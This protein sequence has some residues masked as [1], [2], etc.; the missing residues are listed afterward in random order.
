METIV[1]YLYVAAAVLFVLSL[2]WMSE[3]KTSRMGNWA[4]SA[5]MLIAVAATM[6]AFKTEHYNLVIIA[7]AA[8]TIIGVPIALKLP[9][10]AVPQRTAVS[11]AFGSLAVAL[12]GTAEYYQ[13]VP[14]ID[15]FTMTVLAFEMILGYLTFTGS[16]IAFLKL[17]ETISG[18][19]LIYRGRN[20]VS[21]VIVAVAVAMA[22]GLVV[23]PA[24]TV[25]LP[26]LVISALVFG[27]LLVMS[28]GGADMPTVIAILNSYAGLSAAA[29]GFVLNNQ[30]LIVAGTLDGAS[31]FILAV[32]MCK[33]MNRSFIN[34]LFGGFGATTTGG[35]NVSGSI[36]PVSA[37]EAYFILE[38]ARSVVFVPGYG[39]A[40]A[41]AQH[42]LQELGELLE[43]NGAEVSYGIHPVAG[44]MP[45]H[46]NVLL[47]EADVSYD[48]LIEAELINP[49]MPITDVCMVIGANDV[50]NP[51][52]KE[53]KTSPLWGM[54]IIE[55]DKCRTVI[56]L[57]RS[58]RP[59]F[60]GVENPL[61]FK[62]NTRMLFGDAKASIQSLISEFK[63]A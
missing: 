50:V 25:F 52:A 21:G 39:L 63:S 58:M 15:K 13:H 4:G 19:P 11:H 41:Q 48:Q 54:P 59:G 12:V 43:K 2:K 32:I 18:K 44:R 10:A 3:V 42:V 38:G 53:D 33:A 30:L 31:G 47:A 22:V 34:V 35:V 51:A 56:V 49:K 23:N 17:Q 61:F 60:A 5:G 46:M 40:V 20:I 29:L 28:I 36:K 26:V 55:A 7:V 37:E 16:I 62:N 45:G 24:N 27:F 9:M 57:K 8:G 6:I 1:S 14:D